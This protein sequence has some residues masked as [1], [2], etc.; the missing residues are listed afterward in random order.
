MINDNNSYLKE[1]VVQFYSMSS[2]LPPPHPPTSSLRPLVGNL[3]SFR[4]RPA[5]RAIFEKSVKCL[6][7]EARGNNQE[8]Q[9]S[10][11]KNRPSAVSSW[12]SWDEENR[13]SFFRVSEDRWKEVEK[14]EDGPQSFPMWKVMLELSGRWKMVRRALS[15]GI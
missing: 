6:E 3:G 15:Y 8:D 11:R 14:D 12:I 10:H 2:T 5:A 7:K 1:R 9:I 4:N 13:M